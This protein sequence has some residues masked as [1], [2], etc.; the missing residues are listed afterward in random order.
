MYSKYIQVGAK[1]CGQLPSRVQTPLPYSIYPKWLYLMVLCIFQ[2]QHKSWNGTNGHK[3][4][5]LQYKQGSKTQVSL[6][7]T[8]IFH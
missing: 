8:C 5:Y 3:D 6:S 7:C 1:L 2:K 4:L